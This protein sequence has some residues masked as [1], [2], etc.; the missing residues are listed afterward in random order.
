M[1][2]FSLLRT[3]VGLTT[4]IKIVVDSNYGLYLES[5]NSTNKLEST[6]FKKVQ[7]RFDMPHRKT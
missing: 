2:S 4:N 5:I 3:N 1:R 7:S 6:K